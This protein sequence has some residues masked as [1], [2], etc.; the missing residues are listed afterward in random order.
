MAIPVAICEKSET[1]SWEEKS[2]MDEMKNTKAVMAADVLN[3]P[4]YLS[5][6]P[7]NVT[8]AISPPSCK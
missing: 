3:L 4:R 2:W 5:D 6:S 8:V 7:K 1:H